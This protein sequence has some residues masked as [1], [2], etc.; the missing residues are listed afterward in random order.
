[1]LMDA[2][3]TF[4]SRG[5]LLTTQVGGTLWNLA[6]VIRVL[7]LS[8]SWGCRHLEV[9]TQVLCLYSAQNMA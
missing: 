2:L 1:M 9:S 3:I 8:S 6:L 5:S 7:V 4:N